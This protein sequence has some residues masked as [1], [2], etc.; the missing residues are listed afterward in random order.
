MHLGRAQSH[1]VGVIVT[2]LQ[3][4][5]EDVP[6]LGLVVDQSQQRLAARTLQADAEDVLR[7]RIEIDDQQAVV[8]E[9]DARAKAVEN[10]LGIVCRRAAVAGTLRA[11]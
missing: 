4:P 11:G 5:P 9:N 7:R 3:Y 1:L 8:D 6:H 10:S 2:G